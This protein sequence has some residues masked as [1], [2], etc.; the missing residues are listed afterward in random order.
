MKAV[1]QANE[2]EYSFFLS[3][4]WRCFQGWIP[5]P[6]PLRGPGSAGC[7]A[8]PLGIILFSRKPVLFEY[9]ANEW[10]GAIVTRI[11]DGLG[12]YGMGGCGFLGIQIRKGHR[13]RWLVFLLWGAAGWLS[14][15]GS[16]LIDGY[17]FPDEKDAA[18]D[19]NLP[20]INSLI[21][22]RLSAYESSSDDLH[23]LFEN[24]GDQLDLS[25]TRV[26][27]DIPHWRG[28]GEP[29]QFHDDENL[30]DC[31]VLCRSSRLWSV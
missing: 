24:S 21:G 20:C 6:F 22:C 14:I 19:R 17:V 31:L 28:T 25:I 5:I 23:L 9:H 18:L 11:S 8:T 27:K 29:K 1:H 16:P 26:G 15:N 12:S 4:I 3:A 13:K 2:E 7:L 30:S 10:T